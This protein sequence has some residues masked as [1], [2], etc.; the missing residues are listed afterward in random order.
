MS[1]R[2]HEPRRGIPR[3]LGRWTIMRSTRCTS[4]LP[5]TFAVLIT[6]QVACPPAAAQNVGDRVRVA[7]AAADTV[8]GV[9]SQASEHGL[10]LVLDDGGSREYA[11]AEVQ[12]LEVRR[13]TGHRDWWGLLLGGF[14]GLS[15]AEATAPE[16]QVTRRKCQYTDIFGDCIR[17]ADVTETEPDILSPA[18][19]GTVVA[20]AAAGYLAGRLLKSRT[21][22]EVPHP[23]TPMVDARRGRVIMGVRVRF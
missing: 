22:Q 1:S 15:V 2:P 5:A 7:T 19:I 9:L 16:G 17:M 11:H 13:T 23:A 4:T 14:V 21:W 20:G 10:I 18:G 6:F 3:P 12:R 8:V